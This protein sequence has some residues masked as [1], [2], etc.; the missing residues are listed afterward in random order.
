MPEPPLLLADRV[1][2]ISGEPRSMGRGSIVTETDVGSQTFYLHDNRMPGGILIE[3]GQADLMLISWLGVDFENRGERV[4]RLLGCDLTYH[5]ALPLKGD[6]VRYDIHVDG[7]ARQGDV[8]LFFFHYDSITRGP[9]EPP[10]PQL[11][12][13]NGQAGF[14]TNEELADT[15]GVLWNAEDEAV[16]EFAG[17]RLDPPKAAPRPAYSREEVTA[18]S[19]GR[20]RDAFG[21]TH[22]RALTHTLTPRIA[23]RKMLLIH[24]VESLDTAG[25]PWG[26][27]YMRAALD[28][29]EDDWFFKGH[30]KNDP[31]MPGTLMFDGCLQAMAFYLT[32]CGFTLDK[33]A[34]RF[35]PV[36]EMTYKLRCRGQALP[37]SRKLVYEVF[38]A[39]VHDGPEPTLIAD[40]LCTVDGVKAFHARR[41]GLRL[42]ADVPV[43]RDLLIEAQMREAAAQ[44]PGRAFDDVAILATAIGRPSDAFGPS[45]VP[46]DGPRRLSRLPSPPYKFFSRV[47]S[48][49]SPA[50]DAK[51]GASVVAEYDVPPSDWYFEDGRGLMPWAVLLEAALQPCGWLA[52]AT[53]LPLKTPE[54]LYFRNLDGEAVVYRNL[55]PGPNRLITNVTL[56]DVSTSGGISLV[57]FDVVCQDDAGDVLKLS[58]SFGFFPNAAL[59][60]QVGLAT[61]PSEA[62]MFERALEADTF[63][64][65]SMRLSEPA[66]PGGQLALLTR[67]RAL[68]PGGGN[69]RLGSA[70]AEHDVDPSAWFFKA[71]FFQDPVQ[72]GSLGIHMLI[73]LLVV[74]ALE[75]EKK[76]GSTRTQA[77]SVAPSAP[78]VWR[79]RGQV[80]PESKVV[81]V[82]VEVTAAQDTAAGRRYWGAGSLFVDG[83]KIYTAKD[84][85][86]DLS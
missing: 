12:V 51:K 73:E 32:A 72:P 37:S 66:L 30:F 21:P 75:R 31:C 13:R 43:S 47:R 33:D 4:Y 2:S 23:A 24:E 44:A 9:H 85:S 45:Y 28:L 17:L 67:V 52:L 68:W 79:Y 46:F 7:H 80:L 49:N 56:K 40:L 42:A 22:L 53:G 50:G 16:T 1:I 18:F 38:V 35:E 62:S 8:R 41:L 84:L 64:L 70:L 15:G 34:W 76:E 82:L 54:G 5:G 11:S 6:T 3:S 26:R 19:E 20:V 86:V 83:L 29:H 69:A 78:T 59:A 36:P 48:L 58:T 61:E 74:L 57:S 71:H 10:R 63:D 81:S 25:G 77:E 60:R 14:F 27:G 39:E 55:R 65:A